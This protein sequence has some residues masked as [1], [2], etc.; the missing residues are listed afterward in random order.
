MSKKKVK[1]GKRRFR[2]FLLVMIFLILL[3][4]A[5]VMLCAYV[6]KV[7]TRSII[8][9]G[10]SI[11]SDEEILKS[12]GLDHDSNFILAS[13]N[14]VESS[15]KKNSFIKS[16]KVKKNWLLEINIYVEEYKPFFIREDT[17]TIVASSGDEI[18]NSED[19]TLAIPSLINYVPDTK[20]KDL[21][22][23]MNRIDY[24]LIKKISQ[25]MYSPTKYD[26]DRFILY[27]NDSNRVYINLP[28]FKSFNKYDEM[29]TKFEG[30]TGRL[31]LDSGNYF[32]IDK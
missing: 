5:V 20:Y 2:I 14:D 28:K 24:S 30:K 21:I 22:K 18:S 19:Y 8:V 7:P 27:M 9:Q 4:F 6:F 26:E 32:E 25:I 31:Y 17:N 11:V 29:V 23:K 10:N 15:V 16:V 3:L 13:S 12:A 1:K